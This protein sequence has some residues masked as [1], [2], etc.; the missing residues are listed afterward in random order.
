MRVT[1]W[2]YCGP[3]L[4]AAAGGGLFGWGTALLRPGVEITGAAVIVASCLVQLWVLDRRDPNGIT[5]LRRRA[6][7]AQRS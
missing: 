4:I 2:A 1:V 7:E 5:N 3:L 6:R